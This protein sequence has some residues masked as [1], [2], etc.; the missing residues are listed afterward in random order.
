VSAPTTPRKVS[1]PEEGGD[2]FGAISWPARETPHRPSIPI[3]YF[4]PTIQLLPPASELVARAG[5]KAARAESPPPLVAPKPPAAARQRAV[6][7]PS[8]PR[9]PK[10][11]TGHRLIRKTLAVLVVLVLGAALVVAVFALRGTPHHQ[12][13]R[14]VAPELRTTGL[15]AWSVAEGGHV[16]PAVVAVP[17]RAVPVAVAMPPDVLVDSPGG[18]PSTIG[19]GASDFHTLVEVIQGSLDVGIDHEITMTGAD[20]STLVDRAG[21]VSLMAELPFTSNGHRMGP[22][23]VEAKG[24]DVLAYLDQGNDAD[25]IGRWEDVLQGVLAS[26]PGPSGWAQL[27]QG[28]D[29]AIAAKVLGSARGA[30]VLE[31]PTVLGVDGASRPNLAKVQTLVKTRFG[32]LAKPLIRVVI[33]NGNGNPGMGG[34]IGRL[35]APSGFRVVAS[36]NAGSFD[37]TETQVIASREDLLGAANEVQALIG[38]G[39]VYVDAQPTGLADIT[40]VVGKDFSQG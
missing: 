3:L 33:L 10:R 35:I 38:V 16:Y 23:Q 25:R 6:R 32:S 37:L 27:G 17:A 7:K 31:L 2:A 13:G 11:R 12:P 34:A 22:G 30:T 20:L 28:D 18:G 40:I 19:E 14:P 8:P 36:Q 5:A 26:S 15:L 4:G 24:A 29:P 1:V 39:R 21:G 9:L